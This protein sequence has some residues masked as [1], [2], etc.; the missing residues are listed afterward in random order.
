MNRVQNRR[1][2]SI[3]IDP[4]E[5]APRTGRSYSSGA[6]ENSRRKDHRRMKNGN[7]PGHRRE[8]VQD[9]QPDATRRH[10]LRQADTACNAAAC[11]PRAVPYMV[12]SGSAAC[13]WTNTVLHLPS[14]VKR[15]SIV[16]T[17]CM[18]ASDTLGAARRCQRYGSR[19]ET[20]DPTI[21]A[22]PAQLPR[23]VGLLRDLDLPV[24][25]TVAVEAPDYYSAG[26][27]STKLQLQ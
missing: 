8:L 17:K 16:Q 9:D 12:R 4:L 18:R 10:C 19:A 23:S 15:S 22:R 6:H 2:R 7:R 13:T 11:A 3:F 27:H 5:A 1:R 14:C 20:P 21:P 26:G 24:A 25:Q